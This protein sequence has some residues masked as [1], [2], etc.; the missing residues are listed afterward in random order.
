MLEERRA[1][2]MLESCKNAPDKIRFDPHSNSFPQQFGE[3]RRSNRQIQSAR[4]AI[5]RRDSS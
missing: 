2:A 3:A 1:V 5:P 4:H